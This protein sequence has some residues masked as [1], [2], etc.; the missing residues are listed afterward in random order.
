MPYDLSAL[1]DYLDM[2]QIVSVV[3][4]YEGQHGPWPITNTRK[5]T[6]YSRALYRYLA[7]RV[8]AHTHTPFD[9]YDEEFFEH[10]DGGCE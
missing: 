7:S 3:D 1:T 4:R 10:Y 6:A 8:E 2:Q 9:H 5:S